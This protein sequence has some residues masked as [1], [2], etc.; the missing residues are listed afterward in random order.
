MAFGISRDE[1]CVVFECYADGVLSVLTCDFE[2]TSFFLTDIEDVACYGY[3]G[4]FLFIEEVDAGGGA[5]DFFC[6]AIVVP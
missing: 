1:E 6:G 4:F 2:P 5:V 3:C